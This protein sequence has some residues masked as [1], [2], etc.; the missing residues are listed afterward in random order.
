MNYKY[1]IFILI[2]ALISGCNNTEQKN[3][4]VETFTHGKVSIAVDNEISFLISHNLKQYSD[5]FPE[6]Q[7]TEHAVNARAAM[8]EL[9]AGKTR[10]IVVARGYMHDEDSLMKAHHLP[11]HKSF[12]IA[13]DALVFFTRRDFP[14]D[15][16]SKST[17]TE[18]FSKRGSIKASLKQLSHEPVLHVP[19]PSSSVISN[20]IEYCGTSNKLNCGLSMHYYSTSDSVQRAVLTDINSIGVGYLSQIVNKQ[21]EFKMLAVCYTDSTGSRVT[22]KVHQSMVYLNIYPYPVKVM[23][24]LLED[25]RNLPFGILSFLAVEKEPQKSFLD[26]GIVPA[27]AKINVYEE[28]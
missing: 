15:T 7:L 22:K 14:S 10:A 20:L 19:I 21:N 17:L 18:V 9:F 8:G 2:V 27:F 25:I 11:I 4:E 24:Y 3:H 1:C 12:H 6:V 26:A 5:Q 13:T 28:E 23:G 16:I